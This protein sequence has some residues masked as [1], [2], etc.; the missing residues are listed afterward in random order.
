MILRK[1]MSMLGIGSAK[2]DLQLP[3]HEY[4]PG[5]NV[6]G[7]FLIEGGTIDQQIKR[8]ECDLVMITL[9]DEQEEVIDSA[10]ILTSQTIESEETNRMEFNFQLP[11]NIPASTPE[12]TFQ[13]KTRLIFNE[14]V[15]SA[16]LDKITITY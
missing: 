7:T 4:T 3:K 8:I 16:D 11:E 5:E 13:F 10:T 2:I 14:G 9:T 1:Y 6:N 12:R 15:K